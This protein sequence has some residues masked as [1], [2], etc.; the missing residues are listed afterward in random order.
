M[1]RLLALGMALFCVACGDG[2]VRDVES[3]A[4]I[5]V[6]VAVGCVDGPR[7]NAVDPLTVQYGKE[8]WLALA[9]SQKAAAVAAQ[10][11]RHQNRADKIDAA[12]IGCR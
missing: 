11:L 12:T 5:A 6:P 9:L 8:S 4:S 7:P 2:R 3:P 1:K 10:A